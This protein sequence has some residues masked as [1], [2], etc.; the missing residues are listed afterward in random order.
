MT[1]IQLEKTLASWNLG[2]TISEQQLLLRATFEVRL[3]QYYPN[4]CDVF[5]TMNNNPAY[6]LVT[7]RQK[8]LETCTRSP[9]TDARRKNL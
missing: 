6:N 9:E 3:L 2:C 5:Y 8:D 1:S 7:T 4:W